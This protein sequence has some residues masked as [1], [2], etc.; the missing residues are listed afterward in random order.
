MQQ[1]PY[2]GDFYFEKD[3]SVEQF[4]QKIGEAARKVG[5]ENDLYASVMIAQAILESA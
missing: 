4:I 5:Q 3:E 1:N 2:D